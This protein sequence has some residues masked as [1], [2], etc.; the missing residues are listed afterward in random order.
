MKTLGLIGGMS[1]ESS[2]EYY[3]LINEKTREMKNLLEGIE[4]TE[5]IKDKVRKEIYRLAIYS[6]RKS[7]LLIKSQQEKTYSMEDTSN[8]LEEI[9]KEMPKGYT[10][11]SRPK[12]EVNLDTV[13]ILYDYYH[14]ALNIGVGIGIQN[15]T[16][17][18]YKEN[19]KTYLHL[20]VDENGNRIYIELKD[21]LSNRLSTKIRKKS[22]DSSTS[23]ILSIEEGVEDYDGII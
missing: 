21:F 18:L 12:G 20:L 7:E 19:K 5:L 22:I 4:E 14:Q 1:W 3:K 2:I 11:F 10:F 15:I 8:L 23:I 16:T 9:T 6:K 13:K 17:R